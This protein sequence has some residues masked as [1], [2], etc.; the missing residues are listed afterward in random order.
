M[1]KLFLEGDKFIGKS[2]LLKKI[3]TDAN[4]SISGFYVRRRLNDQGQIVG[5]ELRAAKE[6]LED[7]SSL[8]D[9]P[10]YCFI[11]TENGKRTWNL[12]VFETFGLE[13]LKEAKAGVAE[14]ILLDEI[15]GIELLAKNFTQELLTVMQYPKKILGVFKSE[16]NYQRQK[17]HTREKLEVG[18]QRAILRREICKD[19]G[20]IVMLNN[21]NFQLVE[22]QL[23]DFLSN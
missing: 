10:D 22:K 23:V 14:I 18:K 13:L 1:T 16:A 11:Q 17:Q 3:V 21:D 19:K 2:T 7:K 6:L 9:V 20:Q 5:F 12:N 8:K 4:L 15:G